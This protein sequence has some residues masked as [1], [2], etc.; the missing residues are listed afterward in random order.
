MPKSKELEFEDRD[1]SS[2]VEDEL[3]IESPIDEGYGN[4]QSAWCTEF[5][6]KRKT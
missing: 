5:G 1:K 2:N 4:G 6:T 3:L